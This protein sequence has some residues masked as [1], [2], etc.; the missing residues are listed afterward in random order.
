MCGIV[1]WLD[2]SKDLSKDDKVAIEKMRESLSRRGPD[3]G[4]TYIDTWENAQI[5]AVNFDKTPK[6]LAA[7]RTRRTCRTGRTRRGFCALAHRRLA[8]VD[9]ENGRQPMTRGDHTIIYNGELY[10]TEDVRAELTAR[11]YTFTGTGDTEV[12]L[13]AFIEWGARCL[14]K[15]NGIFAFAVWNKKTKKLFVARDR[16][17]VKPLF[18]TVVGAGVVFASELK[19]IFENPHCPAKIDRTGINQIFLLSP[20]R[21]PSSG[22]FRGVRELKP[23]Q[24]MWV[25]GDA[26]VKIRKRTYFKLRA[27]LHT[28]T[29]EQTV[30]HLRNLVLDAVNRQLVADVPLCTFL[31]G[32]LDS[33]IITHA[34]AEKCAREGTKLT[35]YSV[36][37]LDND[38]YFVK[39]TFNPDTDAKYIDVMSRFAKTDHKTILLENQD[40][41]DALENAAIA[42]DLAGMGDVDSSLLLF[43]GHVKNTHTVCL[44]GECADE[45]FG[46]YPWFTQCAQS[47]EVSGFPWAQSIEMRKKLLNKKFLCADPEGFVQKQYDLTVNSAPTLETDTE[48]DKRMRR[49]FKLNVDWFM[50]TLLDRKDR[51]SMYN[52]LEVRVPFGDHRIVQYAYNIPWEMKALGGREKGLLR[53]A[54]RG[55]L[56]DE[57]C[58]RKKAPYPRTFDP[59]FFDACARLATEAINSGGLVSQLINRDYFDLLITEGKLAR[60]G[61]TFRA[62]EKN[63]DRPFY[64]QLM[65]LPQVL[66]WIYQMDTVFKKYNV[67]LV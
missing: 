49:L 64:G 1:G 58:F 27:V 32:G 47:G 15:L 29:T 35:T 5:P 56:P 12:L 30:E 23:A 34:A 66:A 40:V 16:V 44:S 45:L 38:K 31:S 51:M 43:C 4:G 36:D 14:Q 60:S 42:R 39:N 6:I 25:T 28:E 61:L 57:V 19:A 10:N 54:F 62:D 53:E 22:V 26:S 63:A 17:G 65:R 59:R 50:Q 37:F 48:V 20:A 46:G 18:Y 13:T 41:V 2:Y 7:G 8:V 9:I 11:G 24:Y 3:A 67:K 52:G 21:I 33:S 55:I